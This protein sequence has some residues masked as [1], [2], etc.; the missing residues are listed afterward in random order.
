MVHSQCA[1]QTRP[2][3][4]V[5][6]GGASAERRRG[7]GE[8]GVLCQTVG[9]RSRGEATDSRGKDD[10]QGEDGGGGTF[11]RAVR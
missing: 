9:R 5:G 2:A 7:R 1:V 11:G 4:G 3:I 10:M 6:V 8:V